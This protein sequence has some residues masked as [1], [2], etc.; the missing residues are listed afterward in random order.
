MLNM[1]SKRYTAAM[2]HVQVQAGSTLKQYLID[3][4]R[5]KD[6]FL[7]FAMRDILVRYRQA[8]FG[9][10]WALIR[11]LLTVAI[12]AVI[13]GQI[14]QLPSSGIS[15]GLFALAA[16]LPWQLFANVASDTSCC[17]LNHAP[18]LTKTY[19]PRLVIPASQIAIHF[20]DFLVGMGCF[21]LLYLFMAFEKISW[22]LLL[23]PVVLCWLLIFCL[24]VSFWLSA[25]TVRYRDLRLV[26]P[27]VLQFGMLLSPIAYATFVLPSHWIWFYGLNP[28]VGISDG[29]RWL[30]FSIS[31]PELPW[32]TLSSLFLS[33]IL[34]FSGFWY[35]R[36]A[37][38]TFADQI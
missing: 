37:E 6:L 24:G 2:V 38:A 1:K 22:K 30:F 32:T 31:Y 14:A 13:F 17:L 18:L 20:L 27:F 15:Y 21:F 34:F 29:F 25:L 35:F 7:F 11:P 10:G 28:M 26:V 5:A 33:C 9:I 4:A 19:F 16:F 23:L 12:F 8:L 3:L 36:K